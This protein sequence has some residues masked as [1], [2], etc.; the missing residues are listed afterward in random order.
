[1]S[2]IVDR[3]PG[4]AFSLLDRIDRRF[5][6]WIGIFVFAVVCFG[7]RKSEAWILVPPGDWLKQNFAIDQ[8]LNLAMRAFVEATR[9]PFRMVG[10]AVQFPL[11][12]LKGFLIWL[13]WPATIAIV[14]LL[15]YRANGF[16]LALFAAITLIYMAVVGYWEE[17]M[18]TL[19]LVGIAVPVS[20]V[21]GLLIGIWAAH[22]ATVRRVVKP[23]LDLMQTVP[24]F[25]YLTPLILL[26]GYGP[27]VG[28]VA[29]VIYA[30]PPMVRNVMVGIM[31]VAPNTVEAGEMSGTTR[32][33]LT[34]WV[35]VPAAMPS[36]MMGLNQCVMAS[37]SMVIIAAIIGGFA[38]IGWEVLSTLRRAEFGP[39]LLSG[40]V[41]ALLAMMIDRIGRGFSVRAGETRLPPTG[42][43]W[44]RYPATMTALAIAASFVLLGYVF[45]EVQ[46]YPDN[47][48][49]YPAGPLNEMVSYVSKNWYEPLDAFKNATLFFYLLPLRIGLENSVRANYWGFDMSPTVTAVYVAMLIGFAWLC[50]R[51]WGWRGP[52]AV[53]LLGG[54][55][56]FGTTGTP[57]PVFFAIAVA[58][59]WIAGGWRLA[60]FAFLA[61]L[62]ILLGNAWVPAMWSVYLMIASVAICFVVGSAIGIWAA[63]SERVSAVIRPVNDTLQTMPQFVYLIPVIMLFKI[64][65][66]SA[67]LAIIAY[68]IVPAI[69][70]MEHG[71]RTVPP[72]VIEAARAI[73]CTESQ[74]LWQVRLPLALP[75]VML[76]LNQT[77]MF[78]FAMLVITAL[79]GTRDLGQMVFG[80]LTSANFGMGVIAGGSIALL[81]MV[82]DRTLQA[83]SARQARRLG[84]A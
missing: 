35:E 18:V 14:T 66:F 42:P 43:I 82:T 17:S 50:W 5:L 57:W 26:L 47:W 38:D 44:Q 62:F 83:L 29:A 8:W 78:A 1:M 45:P 39:S 22:S 59:T 10:T 24:T 4:S 65:D 71:L 77:I 58:I 33:Q 27:Q 34:W 15:A 53:T 23:L 19:S 80:S 84:V 9:D 6:L 7:L 52:V 36:I 64:G 20:A 51:K 68:A 16:K 13:P 75:Q 30:V 76:G 28:L 12:W 11:H 21:L 61:L 55:Y 46:H 69:R 3:P 72:H 63:N 41:I 2:V 49:I 81:A 60:L 56:Y 32:R 31:N 79:I 74:I 37:L 73:G 25:A 70:Y 54:L 67:M 40:I 48:R